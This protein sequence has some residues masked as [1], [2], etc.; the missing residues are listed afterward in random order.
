MKALEIL[1]AA[2][3]QFLRDPIGSLFRAVLFVLLFYIAAVVFMEVA[4]PALW[5]YYWPFD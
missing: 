4:W 5:S 2:V 3:E 1:A